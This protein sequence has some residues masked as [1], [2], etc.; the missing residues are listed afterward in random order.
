MATVIKGVGTIPSGTSEEVVARPTIMER[1]VRWVIN[2]NEGAVEEREL[3][4]QLARREKIKLDLFE[5]RQDRRKERD[6][7]R[8]ERE[9]KTKLVATWYYEYLH[10]GKDATLAFELQEG[11]THRQVKPLFATTSGNHGQLLDYGGNYNRVMKL[12]MVDSRW[13]QLIRPWME[14]TLTNERLKEVSKQLELT[15]IQFPLT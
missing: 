10:Q 5:E 15:E 2:I 14:G 7:Q 11:K 9:E 4:L 12:A 8:K 13:A 6:S 3:L 1:L